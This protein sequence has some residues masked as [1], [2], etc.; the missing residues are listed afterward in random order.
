MRELGSILQS[1]PLLFMLKTYL[2]RAPGPNR[3]F[4]AYIL[5]LLL[6]LMA[7]GVFQSM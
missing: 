6:V 7:I 3:R 5:G 4:I 2:R 1:A